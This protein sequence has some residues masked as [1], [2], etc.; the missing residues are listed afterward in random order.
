MRT[1][2]GLHRRCWQPSSSSVKSSQ[3]GM[4]PCRSSTSMGSWRAWPSPGYSSDA[5]NEQRQEAEADDEEESPALREAVAGGASSSAE[6]AWPRRR[7]VWEYSAV[8]GRRSEQ[9]FLPHGGPRYR[10]DGAREGVSFR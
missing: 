9:L 1:V 3:I 2:S 10:C 7:G 6:G 5:N 8:C 4:T